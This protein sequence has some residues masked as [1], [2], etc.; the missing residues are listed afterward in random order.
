[1]DDGWDLSDGEIDEL[2]D[3]WDEVDSEAASYLDDHL[4]ATGE[5]PELDLARAT[6]ELRDGVAQ[7]A[8]PYGYF[9]HALDWTT[10]VPD[11]SR[12]AW[13]EAVAATISP[14]NDP[15]I[16][17]ELQSAVMALEHA[18]WL[19]LVIGLVRRGVGAELSADVVQ[20][21]VDALEDIE[22]EVEDRDGQLS[23]L[24]AAVATL[25]PLWQALGV[26]DGSD[27]LTALGRWGLPRGLHRTWVVPEDG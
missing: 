15:R 24:E 2:L 7:G 8:W 9:V 12:T 11:R 1:M 21:D 18:D 6:R 23:V 27:R 3:A 19:G 10:G 25:S 13:L 17:I 14:P 4:P 22:G 5:L 16:D 20:E 26:L